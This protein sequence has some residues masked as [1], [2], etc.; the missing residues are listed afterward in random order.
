MGGKT[1]HGANIGMLMLSTH[2]PRI[3]GDAGHAGS[4]PFPLLYRV[5]EAATAQRV[6][7]AGQTRVDDSLLAPFVD[8]GRALVEMGADA[9]TTS[10]GFLVLYQDRLQAALGVP[11]ATSALLQIPMLQPLFGPRARI[12]VVTVSGSSLSAAHLRAAGAPADT[13]VQGTEAG[14]ELTR[15]L[16]GDEP[17]LDPRL[18]C[19]DVVQAARSLKVGHPGLAAIV[20][21]C[22]N[23]VPYAAA[24]TRATG[25]PVYTIRSLICWLHSGIVPRR[26]DY[27][28]TS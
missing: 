11:V 3:L 22:T 5:V 7:A 28:S 12:G 13:P 19:E 17:D 16:L 2:F 10:C 6:V 1:V 18:A 8:A 4:W 26:F 14:R 23:M 9:I 25:L 20:L 24:V 15:V 27:T 21:E